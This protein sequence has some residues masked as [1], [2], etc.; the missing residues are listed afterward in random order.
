VKRKLDKQSAAITFRVV[1]LE[2]L[3]KLEREL[4]AP[5]TLAKT[6]RQIPFCFQWRVSA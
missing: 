3:D 5:A 1:S 4:R 6:H 2:L